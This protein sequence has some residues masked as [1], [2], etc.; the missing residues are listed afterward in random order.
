MDP[1][2]HDHRERVA[3]HLVADLARAAPEESAGRVRELVYLVALRVF[4][5]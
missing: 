3:D 2:P 4:G 5:L 1:R